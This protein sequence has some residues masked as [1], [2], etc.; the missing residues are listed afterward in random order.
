MP[1]SYTSILPI[2]LYLHPFIPLNT[3]F[4]HKRIKIFDVQSLSMILCLSPYIIHIARVN[5]TTVVKF[6]IEHYHI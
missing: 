2:E 1:V 4:V 5:K 3:V 6:H